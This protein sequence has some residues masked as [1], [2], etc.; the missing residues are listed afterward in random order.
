M[1]L[2]EEENGIGD[3]SNYHLILSKQAKAVAMKKPL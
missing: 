3:I 1:P 2:E